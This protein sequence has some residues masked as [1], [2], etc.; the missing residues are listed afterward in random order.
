[1]EKGITMTFLLTFGLLLF[2]TSGFTI[3]HQMTRISSDELKRVM[4]QYIPVATKN[5]FPGVTKAKG[6]CEVYID[7][8]RT[9]SDGSSRQIDIGSNVN[10]VESYF[11]PL[12]DH[13]STN[14]YYKISFEDSIVL[15]SAYS[16]NGEFITSNL[17]IR[18]FKDDN[19]NAKL[20]IQ[21]FQ[22]GFTSQPDVFNPFDRLT[23][24]KHCF[25]S[26]LIKKTRQAW[27]MR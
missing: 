13:A 3:G 26:S 15:R 10:G 16:T 24:K 25:I 12:E 27:A 14:S 5:Y 11:R 2:S 1:M 6:T 22:T 18:K 19:G 8:G 21:T 23:E 9:Y 7:Y 17:F 4:N 20:A